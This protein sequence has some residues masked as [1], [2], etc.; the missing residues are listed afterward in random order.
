MYFWIQNSEDGLY[1]KAM[2]QDE[3]LRNIQE[4]TG[5]EIKPEYRSIFVSDIPDAYA[6]TNRVCIIKGETTIPSP[7]ARV[8]EWTID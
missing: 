4:T 8:T 3:L 5:E 6:D 7:V 1:V 2:T